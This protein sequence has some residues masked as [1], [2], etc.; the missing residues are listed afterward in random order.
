MTENSL[1]PPT[2]ETHLGDSPR[3]TDPYPE[4][5]GDQGLGDRQG[6]NIG[7]PRWQTALFIVVGIALIV[8]FLLL[9]LSGAVGPGTH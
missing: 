9:H 8:L 1:E 3:H 4:S 6:S 5:K 7:M 2:E